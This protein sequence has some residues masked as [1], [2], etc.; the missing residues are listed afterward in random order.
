MNTSI[1][2]KKIL[3]VEDHQ[4]IINVIHELLSSVGFKNVDKAPNAETAIDMMAAVRYDLV[5]SDVEMG[6]VNGIEL[7]K[8]IRC[9]QTKLPVDTRVIILTSHANMQVLG[10]A[11]A[12]DVNGFLVKPAKLNTT[13]E[14]IQKAFEETFRPRKSIAYSVV[15]TAVIDK[16]E[17]E[18]PEAAEP[19]AEAQEQE[20][21]RDNQLVG[22]PVSTTGHIEK[23]I[24][25]GL[26]EDMM[27]A[28]PIK[29]AKGMVLMPAGHKLSASN[30]NRLQE[31][32]EQ[33]A[34]SFARVYVS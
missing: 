15:N 33:L 3:L 6:A 23:V 29:N 5:I 12:L 20:S 16:P 10:A 24:L 17:E 8:M 25:E 4:F 27:L 30:I 2:M 18:Q 21:E 9:A 19:A 11:M 14:K 28:E 26:E 7:L 22:A 34:D 32:K 1:R 31:L 13:V